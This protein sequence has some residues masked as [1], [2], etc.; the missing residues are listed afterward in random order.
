MNKIYGMEFNKIS[1]LIVFGILLYYP[2]YLVD[3]ESLRWLMATI[4]LVWIIYSRNKLNSIF[5]IKSLKKI[6]KKNILP[7]TILSL[8]SAFI[9]L[10]YMEFFRKFVT[11]QE[12]D[13]VIG[14]LLSG[15][16]SVDEKVHQFFIN[17]VVV[18]LSEELLFRFFFMSIV[19]MTTKSKVISILISSMIF[20]FFH[21]DMVI[22][23]IVGIFAASL[24]FKY[25]SIYSAI[26]F[27]SFYNAW[28]NFI[29]VHLSPIFY[30][31]S[32]SIISSQH[33]GTIATVCILIPLAFLYF[34]IRLKG[35]ND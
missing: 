14:F 11:G 12:L 35:N 33:I 8:A 15:E 25:M 32:W 17:T 24:V 1:S 29:E 9:S 16:L 3:L 18:P 30:F 2:L 31:N 6:S 27:H 28:M 23:F 4:A 5:E 34:I 10:F 21:E 13:Y 7:I 20:S 22:S 26:I 19:Y